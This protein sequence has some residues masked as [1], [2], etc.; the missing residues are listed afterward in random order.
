M[1]KILK[2]ALVAALSAVCCG[3]VSAKVHIVPYP[4]EITVNEGTCNVAG[5]DV[6]AGTV[7]MTASIVPKSYANYYDYYSYFFLHSPVSGHLGCFHVLAIVNNAAMNIEV[8][9]SF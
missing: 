5:V 7:T 4:Q 6:G 9:V 2:F 3:A 8:Y 1:N